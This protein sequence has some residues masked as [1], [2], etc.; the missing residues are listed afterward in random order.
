MDR[1]RDLIREKGLSH[2][3]LELLEE[4]I[5]LGSVDLLRVVEGKESGTIV[6]EYPSLSR[7]RKSYGLFLVFLNH[8]PGRHASGHLRSAMGLVLQH[9]LACLGEMAKAARRSLLEQRQDPPWVINLLELL[10]SLRTL[11]LSPGHEN[12]LSRVEYWK[13]FLLEDREHIREL[14]HHIGER[15]PALNRL[16]NHEMKA[17]NQALIQYEAS[18]GKQGQPQVHLQ[19]LEKLLDAELPAETRSRTE[20]L[21]LVQNVIDSLLVSL[22]KP[23]DRG[24]NWSA[25]DQIRGSL[26]WLWHYLGWTLPRVQEQFLE[27]RVPL[28]V[29]ILLRQVKQDQPAIFV[30]VAKALASHLALLSLVE[31]MEPAVNTSISERYAAVATFFVVETELGRLADRVYHPRAAEWLPRDSE[32]SFILGNFLRQAVLGLVQD[33]ATIRGLLQQTL[34][35]NDVDQLAGNLD[36]LRALLIHH[37]RQLMMDLVGLFS[38]DFRKKLLPDFTSQVEEGD[39]LR[40]RVYR[41]REFLESANHLIKL[42]AEIQDLPRLALALGQAQNQVAAFRRSPEFLLIR[43]QERYE[44]ERLTQTLVKTLDAPED[45]ETALREASE[46]L[47]ELFRFLDDF[48]RRINERPPL[49][50]LDL[51]H[52]REACRLGGFLSEMDR[53]DGERLRIAHKLIQSTKALGVRDVQTMTL[54]KNWVGAER[55]G[56]DA[57]NELNSLLAHLE[58][59]ARCLESSLD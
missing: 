17:L 43:N 6:E 44:V 9:N 32:E 18:G 14:F 24:V 20:P 12:G 2:N 21:L 35:S 57:V 16:L 37:Q 7:L 46:T 48:L 36:N 30:V 3:D 59:L 10:T 25:V 34:A 5:R 19:K 13:T 53:G 8:F 15:D 42:H 29:R 47:N 49:I 4:V 11:H 22:A 55:N 45:V 27:D 40:Q 38:P 28:D 50:R 1:V 54:L 52:S 23:L 58:S 31:Q 33:Q 26:Q 39:R 56:K 51:G 41:M